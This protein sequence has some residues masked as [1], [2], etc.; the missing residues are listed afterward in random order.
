ML[1][2]LSILLIIGLIQLSSAWQLIRARPLSRT[3]LAASPAVYLERMVERK[4]A[5]V[6]SLLRRHEALDDPL[7]LRMNYLASEG[8]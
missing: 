8:R 7:F 3:V 2:A 5:E 4:K 1:A 6:E